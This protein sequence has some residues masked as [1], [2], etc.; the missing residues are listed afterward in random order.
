MDNLYA[1]LED[2]YGLPFGTLSAVEHVES[3]GNDK[4]VSPKGA[5]GRFQFMP[6]T[7]KAYNVDVTD[8]ISSATGAAKYLSDLAKHY[9]AIQPAIAHYNGGTAAGRAVAAGQEPPAKETQDYLQKVNSNIKIDPNKIQ[10][11]DELPKAENVTWDTGKPD[12][13]NMS[14][15]ELFA[16]G[17]K[18]SAV[19]TITGLGQAIDP[20]ARQL[21][22]YFPA[23]SKFGEKLGFT[24]TEQSRA[25]IE[26][27]IRQNRIQDQGILN[28][29]AGMVGNVAGDIG[30]ALLLPGGTI[31]KTAGAG[32]ALAGIQPTLGNENRL[33]NALGGAV[34]G[35]IGQG[36]V[37]GASRLVRPV[38]KQLSPIAEKGVQILKDAGVPLDLAQ[39]TGSNVLN[40]AKAFLS[41]NY[42]TSPAQQAFAQTQ[43]AAYN[44]AIANTFGED[45]THIT[46]DVIQA[47][48]DRLGANYDAIVSRNNIHLDDVLENHLN[49]IG[50]EAESV[51]N[52]D[53]YNIVK[54]QIDNILAKADSN[55]GA[56]H[57]NQYQ[58]IKEVLDKISGGEN[59]TVGGYARELKDSLLDGLTRSAK[60]TGNKEDVALLKETNKQYGNMKKVENTVD[61]STGEISPAKLYNH[62]KTKTNRYSFYQDDPQLANLAMAGKNILGEKM[63]NSGTPARLAQ[64]AAPA[65]LGGAIGGL[66][67][68]D[69]QGIGEGAV[70]GIGVPKL[71]QYGINNPRAAQALMKGVSNTP[72][73]AIGLA[74]KYFGGGKI[75]LADYIKNLNTQ[76]QQ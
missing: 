41:D 1:S 21:N 11:S 33:Q 19:N 54:K 39:Q 7:A 72:L 50:K 34:S 3:R 60:A 5:K 74:P 18:S 68:G 13:S 46:K 52:P 55:G 75:P 36:V 15:A 57:G 69:L 17:L 23:V 27:E 43:K 26:N 66:Q 40:R 30:Q 56:I 48:K 71:V 28:T 22:E 37:E 8:P 4:A 51:L 38:A 9:G 14:N 32:A 49:N 25:G 73:R 24:P 61:F 10:W 62:L 67:Q 2:Q 31:A 29:P 58:A 20:L 12:T 59:Q 63:P 45:A 65:A 53:N 16:R 76:E 6:E 42:I 47:A 35:A 64:L 44:K 70:L